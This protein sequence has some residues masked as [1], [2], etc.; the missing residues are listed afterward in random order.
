M[1]TSPFATVLSSASYILEPM[2]ERSASGD[3]HESMALHNLSGY[4]FLA[5]IKH[6]P[7]Y[8]TFVTFAQG[9][10]AQMG[11]RDSLV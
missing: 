5:C 3:R 4:V 1:V 7:E 6:F 10:D 9:A 2:S 11:R 8:L